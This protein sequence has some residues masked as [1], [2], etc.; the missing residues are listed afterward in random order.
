MKTMA[1]RLTESAKFLLAMLLRDGYP[2]FCTREKRNAYQ[3]IVMNDGG[4]YS[5]EFLPGRPER[6]MSEQIAEGSYLDADGIQVSVTVNLDQEGE[7]FELDSRKVNNDRLIRVLAEDAGS[8]SNSKWTS[9]PTMKGPGEMS[10]KFD[11]IMSPQTIPLR[12]AA[13]AARGNSTP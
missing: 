4:V 5:L 10:D 11:E 6:K 2:Q 13:E 3:V 9:R 8:R 7:M 12:Q 1:R